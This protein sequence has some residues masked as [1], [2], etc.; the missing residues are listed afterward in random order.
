MNIELVACGVCSEAN[1]IFNLFQM[2]KERIVKEF[3]ISLKTTLRRVCSLVFGVS[4]EVLM[5]SA[6]FVPPFTI[7]EQREFSQNV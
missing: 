6:N 1:G 3:E 7:K 2:V 5:D 4:G